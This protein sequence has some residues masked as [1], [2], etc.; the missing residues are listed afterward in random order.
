MVTQMALLLHSMALPRPFMVINI[1]LVYRKKTIQ[2]LQ[3]KI[4]SGLIFF[5]PGRVAGHNCPA[6]PF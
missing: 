4:E 5:D 2:S 6:T 1:S 3:K